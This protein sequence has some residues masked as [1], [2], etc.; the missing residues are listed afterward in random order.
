MMSLL[1]DVERLA[2]PRFPGTEGEKRAADLV[3]ERLSAAGLDVTREPFRAS[4]TAL[5]RLRLWIH[6]TV[7]V[8]VIVFAAAARRG[9]PEAWIVGAGTL[10]LALASSRWRGSI[11]PAFDIGP[12]VASENVMGRRRAARAGDAPHVVLLAHLDSK[13]TRFPTLYPASIILATLVYLAVCTVVAALAVLRFA[14]FPTWLAAVGW[15]LAGALVI[16][17]RNPAGNESP[18]AMDNASGLAVLLALAETLPREGV[19][20]HAE[21]TFLAT[22]AEE[23][24]LAGAMRWIAA[25]EKELDRKRTVFVNVDS[26]GVGQG[27]LAID[28]RGAMPDG[29]SMKQVVREAARQVGV[30]LRV[31]AF[32]PGTGVDTMPIGTRGF[33]TVSILGQVIGA[34]A[35]RIHSERDTVDALHEAGLD[36]AMRV[37]AQVAREAAGAG[38][39]VIGGSGA[40]GGVAKSALGGESTSGE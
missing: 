25:H 33:A 24:G 37:C 29:R 35:R 23:I 31:L 30:R 21:L 36:A 12:S 39:G 20:A 28:V 4:R 8:A 7:A 40:S 16:V 38:P 15:A 6:G 26:V 19:L 11:E 18:G 34:P 2:F 17:A 27:L 22:G 1:Q 5:G 13:S 32:L 9:V 3:A 10:A 14:A